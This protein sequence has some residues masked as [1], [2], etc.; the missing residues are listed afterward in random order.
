MKPYDDLTRLGRLRR[1]RPLAQQALRAFGLP[2]AHLAFLQYTGNVV[3][4]VDARSGDTVKRMRGPYIEDRY[5]LRILTTSDRAAVE[6]ELAWLAA[7][8]GEAGLPVPQPVPTEDGRL[9][10]TITTPGVAQGRIVS[11]MRWIDGRRLSTGFRPSHF[12][13][14]GRMIAR[15][16]AFALEWQPPKGFKRPHWDWAGQLGGEHFPVSVEELVASMPPRIQEPFR[17]VS[18]QAKQ[19]MQAL[20]TG[21]EAYGLIHSDMYPEN[22]LF[23]AG[24]VFPIDFED[25]GYGYW[26]WDLAVPLC[27]WPWTEDWKWKRDALLGGYTRIRMLPAIQLAQLD[28]FMAVQYATMVLWASMFILHDPARR[29]E[30]QAWRRREG[31]NLLRYFERRAD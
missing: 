25:C 28:L 31:R 18:Q 15:L 1:L 19:A 20:G 4:R 23:K 22:V 8:S 5:L 29:A 3:Y 2:D 7:M 9:L 16:H 11:L 6:S 26:L 21:P 12:T 14:W 24:E 30:H 10:T 17:H 27:S 13:A